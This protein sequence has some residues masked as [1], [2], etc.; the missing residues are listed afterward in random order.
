MD[1]QIIFATSNEFNIPFSITQI[2]HFL[3]WM[4]MKKCVTLI[5]FTM[6]LV[7]FFFYHILTLGR[8]LVLLLTLETLESIIKQFNIS[9]GYT[10]YHFTNDLCFPTHCK[11]F[12]FHKSCYPHS[13]MY[14]IVIDFL[15]SSKIVFKN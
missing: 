10:H 3:V 13:F 11:N 6:T 12:G 4:F 1:T 8:I 9:P 15:N 5:L 2:K 14:S 7:L